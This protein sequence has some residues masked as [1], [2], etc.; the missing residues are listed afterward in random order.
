MK[1]R[2]AVRELFHAYNQ[3]DGQSEFNTR[4]AR[5]RL[6]ETRDN[7][8][9]RKYGTQ[10]TCVFNPTEGLLVQKYWPSQVR[11]RERAEQCCNREF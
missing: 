4:S 9:I 8:A 2:L 10:Y 6:S 1:T 5:L 7:T 11:C 3:I